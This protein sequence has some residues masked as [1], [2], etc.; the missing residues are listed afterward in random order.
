MTAAIS[1]TDRKQEGPIQEP[2]LRRTVKRFRE[3]L[4]LKA[5]KLSVLLNSRLEK[6]K[7]ATTG[8]NGHARRRVL[9]QYQ[10]GFE[11]VLFVFTGHVLYA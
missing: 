9:D 8:G 6:N 4:V 11:H 3:G 10:N 7:K 2:L 1:P 5:H